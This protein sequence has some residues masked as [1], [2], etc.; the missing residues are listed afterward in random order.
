MGYNNEVATVVC[1]VRTK[2]TGTPVN[3]GHFD[4]GLIITG[5]R[6]IGFAQFYRKPAGRTDS[7]HIWTLP[8]YLK[9]PTPTH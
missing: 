8:R 7:E 1:V 6:P 3:M 4:D 9:L 5:G 2:T